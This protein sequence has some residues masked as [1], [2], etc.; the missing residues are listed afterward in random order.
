[1]FGLRSKS[2]LEMDGQS[3]HILAI[4]HVAAVA[5]KAVETIDQE[6]LPVAV[7]RELHIHQH[8]YAITSGN[9]RGGTGGFFSEQDGVFEEAILSAGDQEEFAIKRRAPVDDRKTIGQNIVAWQRE[10]RG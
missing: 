1:M 7:G 6:Q 9:E 10:R 3:S 4:W 2:A 8:V 5:R